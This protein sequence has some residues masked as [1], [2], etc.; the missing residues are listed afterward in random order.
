MNDIEYVGV[1]YHTKFAAATRMTKD[2][3]ILSRDKVPTTKTD[4][5]AFLAK[6]LP[7][8]KVALEATNN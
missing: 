5:Q 8:S 3:T 2:G 6:L 1:D 4:I 7:Y